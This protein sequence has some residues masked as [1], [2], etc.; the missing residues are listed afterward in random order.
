ME[1]LAAPRS[2]IQQENLRFAS[3]SS[4]RGC[5]GVRR[6]MVRP[7]SF[8]YLMK[9]QIQKH[10]FLGFFSRTFSLQKNL[11]QPPALQKHFPAKPRTI[12]SSA[13]WFQDKTASGHQCQRHPRLKR[14]TLLYGQEPGCRGGAL[15]QPS[16]LLPGARSLRQVPPA[17]PQRC[18]PQWGG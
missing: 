11:Q 8:G 9:A 17:W 10:C 1:G 6:R 2:E 16:P 3:S 18:S 7:V 14:S 12:G 5:C 4:S 15:P 13:L